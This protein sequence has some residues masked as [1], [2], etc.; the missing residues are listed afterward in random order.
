MVRKKFFFSNPLPPGT[1][2]NKFTAM[3]KQMNAS[4]LAHGNLY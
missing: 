3:Q 1:I 2:G 4:I